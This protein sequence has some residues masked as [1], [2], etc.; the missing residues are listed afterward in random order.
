MVLIKTSNRS[1][2][3]M[4]VINVGISKSRNKGCFRRRANNVQPR[5]IMMI[6]LNVRQ[7]REVIGHTLCTLCLLVIL[8]ITEQIFK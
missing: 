2:A 5:A 8:V 3:F 4:I 1:V 7:T 6:V